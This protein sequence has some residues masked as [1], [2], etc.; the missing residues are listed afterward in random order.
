MA[1]IKKTY[2]RRER[3]LFLRVFLLLLFTAAVPLFWFVGMEKPIPWKVTDPSDPNFKIE[4]FRFTDY[5][6]E[7]KLELALEI[8]FPVGTDKA[9]V[10][11]IL[12]EIAKTEIKQVKFR[13]PTMQDQIEFRYGHNNQIRKIIVSFM[14]VAG[15]PYWDP[16]HNVSIE[17]EKNFT[18]KSIKVLSVM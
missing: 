10:D 5:T 7:H 18:V 13:H 3:R 4:E 17:Y 1:E 15:P 2:I 6:S 11:K 14:P 8:L 16:S 12:G 9:Y